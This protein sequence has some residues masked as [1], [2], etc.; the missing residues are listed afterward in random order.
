M[1]GKLFSDVLRENDTHVAS[2]K[3]FATCT[4][5]MSEKDSHEA[6]TIM[7]TALVLSKG[8]RDIRREVAKLISWPGGMD[9]FRNQMRE[10]WE[11]SESM[12]FMADIL[13]ESGAIRQALE[14]VEHAGQLS[15]CDPG[16]CLYLVHTY[17][18]LN[19]YNKAFQVACSFI[20]RNDALKIANISFSQIAPFL[21]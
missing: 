9:V 13:R 20:K 3:G 19:E 10:T 7:I 16:I 4:A 14:L 11:S 21:L 17:E 8:E 12:M 6:I 18:I 5:A 2:L 15:P 1:A